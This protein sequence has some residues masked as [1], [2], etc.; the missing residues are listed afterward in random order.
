MADDMTTSV[1]SL[2]ISEE[3]SSCSRT[4]TSRTSRA[5]GPDDIPTMI[6]KTC[7]DSINPDMTAI[8]QRS[9]STAA[10]PTDWLKAN[11]SCVCKKWN[12]NLAEN[13]H[14]VSLTFVSCKLLELII[15][16]HLMFHLQHQKVL[17][18]PNNGFDQA[19]PANPNC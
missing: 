3:L 13:Y 4:W 9:L 17:T 7:A 15:C 8:F 5:C 1:G 14:P 18:H 10:L 11:V 19:S 2:L 16:P 6:L 12:R